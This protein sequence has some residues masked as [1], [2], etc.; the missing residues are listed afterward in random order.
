MDTTT[1][2]LFEQGKDAFLQGEYRLSI[3]Y[4]EQAAANL[5]KATR[6][7]SEVR[8]WLVSSYQAN[9]CSEDAISLCRELTASPFPSTKE[10]AKQQ[11]YILEAPKLERPKE[12]ITQIPSM[13]DVMPIQSVY[14]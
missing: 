13:E 9:N 8:L 4:L 5:S 12:W 11:L 7:G 2:I 10:R 3:E 14:V 6:E 1:Q